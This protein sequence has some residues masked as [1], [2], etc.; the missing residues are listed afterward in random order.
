LGRRQ[1]LAIR[2]FKCAAQFFRL[3]PEGDLAIGWRRENCDTDM[4]ARR[5]PLEN[6]FR[7]P[8]GRRLGLG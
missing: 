2:F 4:L 6:Y 8:P 1:V 7:G 5:A 3:T